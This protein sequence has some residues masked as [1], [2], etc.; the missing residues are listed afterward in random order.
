M[1]PYAYLVRRWGRGLSVAHL[2]D[3][4]G[5]ACCGLRLGERWELVR[6]TSRRVCGRCLSTAPA[7][8]AGNAIATEDQ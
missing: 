2:A 4:R 5:E 8:L 3:E 7:S 1:T 6:A